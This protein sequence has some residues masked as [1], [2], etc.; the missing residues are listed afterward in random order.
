VLLGELIT[1][2][3]LIPAG[4]LDLKDLDTLAGGL[5]TSVVKAERNGYAWYACS[6]NRELYAIAGSIDEVSS[7]M[8]SKPVLRV[9]F[10]DG[11]R[12][13]IGSS[14]WLEMRPNFWTGCDSPYQDLQ[15]RQC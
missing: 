13:V 8:H 4:N 11:K 5:K 3:K 6:C 9:L 12:R 14:K 1:N 15:V 7:R 2:Q 10:Y